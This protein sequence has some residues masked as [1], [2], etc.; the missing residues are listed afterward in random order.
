MSQFY[1]AVVSAANALRQLPADYPQAFAWYTLLLRFAFSA[2]VN[3]FYF[4]IVVPFAEY[5]V[6]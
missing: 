3:V 2:L 1:Q 5:T 4:N 6:F